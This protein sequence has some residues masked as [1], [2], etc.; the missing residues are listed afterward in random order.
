MDTITN[1]IINPAMD[2]LVAGALNPVVL[3]LMVL[4][5]V[6]LWTG[7]AARIIE[8]LEARLP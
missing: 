2:T 1:A 5:G 7:L 6:A 8:A 3:A 4:S